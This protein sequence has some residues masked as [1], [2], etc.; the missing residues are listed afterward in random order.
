VL[1]PEWVPSLPPLLLLL[2]LLLVPLLVLL[3]VPLLVLLLVPLLVLLLFSP[4]LLEG[5][6]LPPSRLRPRD[7]WSQTPVRRDAK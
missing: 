1:L 4:P 7:A 3:L 2:V 5:L 6:L